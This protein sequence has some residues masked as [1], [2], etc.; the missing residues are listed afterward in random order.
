MNFRTAYMNSSLMTYSWKD[1]DGIVEATTIDDF[2]KQEHIYKNYHRYFTTGKNTV[3][4]DKKYPI[5]FYKHIGKDYVAWCRY[6]N[7][8][9]ELL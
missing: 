8:R 1:C 9:W 5:T 2:A 7:K 4:F 3:L 6:V